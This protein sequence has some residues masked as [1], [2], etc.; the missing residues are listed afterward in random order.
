MPLQRFIKAK[1]PLKTKGSNKGSRP[2]D[3]LPPRLS[4]GYLVRDAHRAF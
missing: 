1:R 4:S 2:I 3:I